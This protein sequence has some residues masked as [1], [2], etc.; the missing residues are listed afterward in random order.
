MKGF[1]FS[2]S[3]IRAC[4]FFSVLGF[5]MRNNPPLPKDPFLGQRP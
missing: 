4:K 2:S 1:I 3:L 5:T